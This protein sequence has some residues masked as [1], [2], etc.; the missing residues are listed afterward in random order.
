M[1]S[2]GPV[3]VELDLRDM[4]RRHLVRRSLDCMAQAAKRR[5]AVTHST[6]AAAY[7]ETI[8]SAL[9][10][11][12]GP[13]PVGPNADPVQ[14][15]LVSRHERDGYALEN[16]LF[17]SWPGWEVNAT[18]YV[19]TESDGPYPPVVLSVGHS[20]K[21]F[22]SYQLPAQLLA[23]SGY[24]VA[25]YDPPGMAGE[26]RPGNDH[27]VDGVR[28]YLVGETSARYFVADAL[29]CLD[30]LETRDD[31]DWRGGA[32]AT[33]CSG[34]GNTTMLAALL[35][36]RTDGGRIALSAPSCCVA[37]LATLD[38]DQC[39]AGC[40]E[41]HYPR[42]YALGLD[43]TDLIAAAAPMPQLL[44]AGAHD[45][46]FR[47]DDV[48]DLVEDVRSVY[49]AAGVADQFAFYVDDAGHGYSL[50][51]ARAL[52][53]FANRWVR[54]DPAYPVAP[55]RDDAYQLDPPELLRC[56]PRQDV[57][58]RSLTLV[59][60]QELRNARKAGLRARKDG[61]RSLVGARQAA[62]SAT[63]PLPEVERGAPFRVWTHVWQQLVLKP[64][65][66]DG[67]DIALPATLFT[68]QT[69][70]PSPAVLHLDDRGRLT[71]LLRQ[72]PLA[73]ALGCLGE[74]PH[75]AGM[76]VDLRGWGDSAPAAYPFEL[77][78]WGSPDRCL[79]YMSAA[80]GDPLL[81]Q[82]VRDALASLA[83]LRSLPEV[84]GDRV[85]LTGHGLGGAVALL[86]AAIDGSVAGVV[87]VGAPIS[88][89]ALLEAETPSWP[90]DAY[91]TD[92]L[93][94]LDL[95]ELAQAL[96]CPV[97][98]LSPRDG[99]GGVLL[100][101]DERPYAEAVRAIFRPDHQEP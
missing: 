18:V 71:D 23:R 79:G 24:L 2:Q 15:R 49:K 90:A 42:R 50:A 9:R 82:R 98:V 35:D 3:P 63:G 43:D 58:M 14:P 39:Y 22:A 11:V 60:A 66:V 95:P 91:L 31:V 94:Y 75:Y 101:P 6:D 12:I 38:I 32:I 47:I 68:P 51:Q 16:V 29:R 99:L 92:A 56:Y 26:K 30:Y 76:A 7:C 20:G 61:A 59:R 70:D 41:T 34:G 45:E 5:R 48:R 40:P 64:D 1:L 44:M 93:R 89:E 55:H 80:L 33:G 10:D 4:L 53:K 83:Y 27:F 84:S 74:A 88:F 85:V 37:P 21:Q 67:A 46:V 28:P 96:D 13:L 25:T 72:G 81:A 86:A 69:S 36:G 97:R 62:P 8:R 73:Q 19:P 65:A 78:S 52:A 54:S 100:S 87:T 77:A 17:C 57:H